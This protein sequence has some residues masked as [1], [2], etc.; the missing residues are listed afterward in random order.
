VANIFAQEEFTGRHAKDPEFWKK[1]RSRIAAVAAADV[2][3]VAQKYLDLDKMVVL[4]VG[5]KEDIL[6]GFPSHPAKFQDLAGGHFT[7]LPLRDPMTM[8]PLPLD[9]EKKP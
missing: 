5:N 3:R 1:Y 2:Q 8:K 4:V 6:L 9:D 7:E